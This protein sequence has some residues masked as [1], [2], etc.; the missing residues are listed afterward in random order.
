[1]AV[2]P[3]PT[4]RELADQIQRTR[5][6][7]EAVRLSKQL[8]QLAHQRALAIREERR[9]LLA[10]AREQQEPSGSPTSD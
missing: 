10:Q 5:D 7:D 6:I 1:M 3:T 9:R 2:A 8:R 4:I